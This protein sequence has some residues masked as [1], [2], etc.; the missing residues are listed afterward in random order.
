M[1]SVKHMQTLE[2]YTRVQLPLRKRVHLVV[3]R[4]DRCT[5]IRDV[6]YAQ[7]GRIR[8]GAHTSTDLPSPSQLRA[9]PAPPAEGARPSLRAT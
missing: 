9:P 8:S 6:A 4:V 1:S 5:S 7:L 3:P 2:A